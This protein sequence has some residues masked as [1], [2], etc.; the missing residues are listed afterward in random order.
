MSNWSPTCTTPPSTTSCP[1]CPTAPAWSKSS[2]PPWPAPARDDATLSLVDL[3]HFAET[4][5]ALGHQFG[6]TA[7]GR[8]GA[9]A[10]A[11]RAGPAQSDG[12]AHRRRYLLRAGRRRARQPGRASWRC[13]DAPFRIDGQDVQL[14][15]TLGLVRLGEHDGSGADALKDADIA[16]KR[17]KSQQ[18]AG[19]FYF[20]RS[21]GV[22][23][24]E[25]VR[26]M[27]ALR[28]GFRRR[29]SCSWCTSRRSTWPPA[30]PVGAEALLRWQTPDGKFVSPDR[31]IPIAEYSGL[32][33]DIGE[34]VLRT[35]CHEAGAPARGRPPR[36]HHVGQ[37]LAGAVPPPAT[38][39]TC[40]ARALRRHAARRPNSSNWKS[41]NR[42]PW[43]SRTC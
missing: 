24:R 20:S 40:C 28:T 22:E 11:D 16:L 2:T 26:M 41:P 27:H 9:A 36:L 23:I 21:M 33:I 6:D 38:S 1:S 31:F 18:R 39:S 17:A 30:A 7:A 3:D 25:R 43:K 19:H 4:N 35:A 5:D 34:W 42:W 10:P 29:A 13:S 14:S 12:G 15:A 32:I 37:R 8:R